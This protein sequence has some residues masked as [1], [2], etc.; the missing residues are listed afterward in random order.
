MVFRFN[1]S[2]QTSGPRDRP[3]V[4]PTPPFVFDLFFN[5]L[6]L[7]SYDPECVLMRGAVGPTSVFVFGTTRRDLLRSDGGFGG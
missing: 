6:L 7:I 2:D 3:I 5:V 1:S 4:F